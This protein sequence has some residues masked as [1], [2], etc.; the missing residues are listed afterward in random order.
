MLPLCLSAAVG[1]DEMCV[2]LGERTYFLGGCEHHRLSSLGVFV[3]YLFEFNLYC[4]SDVSCM[5]VWI[6]FQYF[7]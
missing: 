3:I 5:F 7:R 2:C 4:V 1:D 6:P